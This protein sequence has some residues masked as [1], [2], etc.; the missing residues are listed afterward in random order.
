MSVIYALIILVVGWRIA[1]ATK[2]LVSRAL[3]RT[4]RIDATVHAFLASLTYYFVLAVVVIAV[5]QLFGI[6]TTSLI[7]VLGATSL[8]IGLALQGTLTNLAAGVMI[9]AFRPF[10]QGDYIAVA[11]QSGTVK[12][13]TLFT[14]ELATPDNVQIIVPNASAWGTTVTNY[15]VYATR[16]LEVSVGIS[17]EDDVDLAL[18]VL[19]AM[20]K[21]DARVLADPAP[22][23]Y[24]AELADSQVTLSLRAWCASGDLW[25]LKTDF[26]R[27]MKAEI[28][29]A[30]M[31]IPYPHTTLVPPATAP[32]PAGASS[33]S[34]RPT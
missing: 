24:V 8:A 34:A 9:L 1:H 30:G 27:R 29:G 20:A 19:V 17:Y 32:A 16:R 21:S 23:A 14:T 18:D 31:N 25:A 15:S 13:I 10:K 28:E 6:Q 3:A 12:E 7:T 5:L 4:K 33:E 2:R 22:S 26:T 11:G